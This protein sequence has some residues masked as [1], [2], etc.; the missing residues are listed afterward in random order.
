MLTFKQ[1]VT[2]V[3]DDKLLRRFAQKNNVDLEIDTGKPDRWIVDW[4][5]RDDPRD[6]STK[7]TGAKVMRAISKRADKKGADVHLTTGHH[8]LR[9]YY[10]QFGYATTQEYHPLDNYA[11]MKREPKK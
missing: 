5:G 2:E 6:D 10:R 1:F 11:S 4:I 9:K 8:K 3:R 7:G